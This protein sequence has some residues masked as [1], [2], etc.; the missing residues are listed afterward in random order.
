MNHQESIVKSLVALEYKEGIKMKPF[1]FFNEDKLGGVLFFRKKPDTVNTLPLWLSV[2]QAQIDRMADLLQR[3]AF[4]RHGSD[5]EDMSIFDAA[6]LI[7][8]TFSS[9]QLESYMGYRG[10]QNETP[11]L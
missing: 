1:A 5:D 2:E 9:E 8:E 4:P 11:K 10:N 3:I 6:K 7:Q